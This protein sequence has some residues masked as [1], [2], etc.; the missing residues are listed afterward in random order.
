LEFQKISNCFQHSTLKGQE[1]KR[2][3]IVS[4]LLWRHKVW[5]TRFW[6]HIASELLVENRHSFYCISVASLT[7]W[8]YIQ[9]HALKC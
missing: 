6:S 8:R 2:W 5:G 3:E 1:K 9:Y 4:S 7:H